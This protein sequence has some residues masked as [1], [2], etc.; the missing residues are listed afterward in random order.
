MRAERHRLGRTLEDV[1]ASAQMSGGMLSRIENARSLPSL[2]SLAQLAR[3]LNVPFSDFFSGLEGNRLPSLVKAGH[4]LLASDA[5]R[6]PGHRDEI[7]AHPSRNR[8]V[9]EPWMITLSDPREEF[10]FYQHEGVG[11]IYVLEGSFSF[12]Y[13]QDLLQM[14][15]GDTLLYDT[16]VPHRPERPNGTPVRFLSVLARSPMSR[17]GGD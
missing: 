8:A 2:R 4:G 15:P 12:R 11:L 7:L 10:P 17:G 5:R 16:S 9:M 1:A 6:N 13:G 14:A 3:S